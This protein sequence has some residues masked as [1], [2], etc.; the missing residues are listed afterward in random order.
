[1]DCYL[2]TGVT[3]SD[4]WRGWAG[5]AWRGGRSGWNTGNLSAPP[6][7]KL[8]VGSGETGDPGPLLTPLDDLLRRALQSVVKRK[9]DW[10]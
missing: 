1:M 8:L 2:W 6:A 7:A 10:A 4:Y 5:W 9:F 3:L